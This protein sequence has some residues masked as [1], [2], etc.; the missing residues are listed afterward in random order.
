MS[1]LGMSPGVIPRMPSTWGSVMREANTHVKRRLHEDHPIADADK[2]RRRA[3]RMSHFAT[4]VPSDSSVAIRH[5]GGASPRYRAHTSSSAI[6]ADTDGEVAARRVRS[7]LA[8]SSSARRSPT[9]THRRRMPGDAY[10]RFASEAE[11][12]A[13]SPAEQ[14]G[15]G[16]RGFTTPMAPEPAAMHVRVAEKI[17]SRHFVPREVPAVGHSTGG[18]R[19]ASPPSLRPRMVPPAARQGVPRH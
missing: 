10:Q 1:D 18:Q 4:S 13:A 3:E 12:R 5:G 6:A 9:Q 16:L 7:P 11:H 17:A 19:L 2:L 14:R 8:S 15:G